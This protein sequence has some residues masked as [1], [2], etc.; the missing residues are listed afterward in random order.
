MR[1]RVVIGTVRWHCNGAKSLQEREKE[2]KEDRQKFDKERRA[3]HLGW[4]KLVGVFVTTILAWKTF[5]T[6][7]RERLKDKEE[8]RLFKYWDLKR[9][10]FVLTGEHENEMKLFAQF[11]KYPRRRV[12]VEDADRHEVRGYVPLLTHDGRVIFERCDIIFAL[13]ARSKS[14]VSCN[15]LEQV[16]GTRSERASQLDFAESVVASAVSLLARM[17]QLAQM[18]EKIQKLTVDE[19]PTEAIKVVDLLAGKGSME[20]LRTNEPG[21]VAAV[22]AFMERK[23]PDGPL[24]IKFIERFHGSAKTWRISWTDSF[25]KATIAQYQNSSRHQKKD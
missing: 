15:A 23:H 8:E 18:C 11:M 5:E 17:E 19:Y 6:E 4:A 1:R 21:L 9:R 3:V 20:A 24:A 25:C 12:R 14:D 16:T 2:L 13:S 7:R 22:H 10:L